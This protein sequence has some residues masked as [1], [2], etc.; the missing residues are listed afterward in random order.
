LDQQ[1]GSFLERPPI[2]SMGKE[3]EDL[4]HAV[5]EREPAERQ[6]FL[7]HHFPDEDVRGEVESLSEHEQD[8]DQLLENASWRF[9]LPQT[10][11]SGEFSLPHAFATGVFSHYR[12]IE[13][14]GQGG[15]GVVYKA[16]DTKLH[17]FV[18]LKFL[19]EGR[20]RD[21]AALAR[22]RRE[23]RAASAL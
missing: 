2:P 16:E 6:A 4:Y 8:G 12:L 10:A 18:A 17:R 15:M 9:D 3:V 1:V 22:F 5:L 13:R 21:P 23:A 7:D 14:I 19:P 20:Y 11:L